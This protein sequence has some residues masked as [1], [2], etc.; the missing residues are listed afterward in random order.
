MKM[1]WKQEGFGQVLQRC[2]A[3]QNVVNS[4]I[5]YFGTKKQSMVPK[6]R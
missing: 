4:F 3:L 1:F 2:Q 5:T 6:V